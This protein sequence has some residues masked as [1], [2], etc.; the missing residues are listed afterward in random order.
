MEATN[1]EKQQDKET[2]V[3]FIFL[4]FSVLISFKGYLKYITFYY[5]WNPSK[6]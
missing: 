1:Q 6:S 2:F 4:F 5:L 3:D